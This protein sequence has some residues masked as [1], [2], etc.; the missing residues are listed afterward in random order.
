VTTWYEKLDESDIF[1]SVIVIGEIR[2]GIEQ[3]R[4]RNDTEQAEVLETWL[5]QTTRRFADR[6][7]PIDTAVADTWGRIMAIRPVP[8]EDSLLAATAIEHD[9]VLATRNIADV[10]GL[11]A[12]TINPF[13][14]T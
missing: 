2:K 13:E 14:I 5:Q 7:L 10:S 6:I 4:G 9:M 3:V 12:Q 8:V 1:T 11:G